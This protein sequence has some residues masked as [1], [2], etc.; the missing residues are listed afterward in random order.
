MIDFHN[1]VV[2]STKKF[3]FVPKANPYM[4]LTVNNFGNSHHVSV[5][6]RMHDVIHVNTMTNLT[7]N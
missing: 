4:T 6:G 5:V 2:F 1:L 7:E 3:L